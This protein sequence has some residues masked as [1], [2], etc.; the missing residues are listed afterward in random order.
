M[1]RTASAVTTEGIGKDRVGVGDERHR[2]EA[3]LIRPWRRSPDAPRLALPRKA[4]RV[5]EAAVHDG[6]L[7]EYL[8]FRNVRNWF[9]D[10]DRA[11]STRPSR[12][13]EPHVTGLS[14]ATAA[15]AVVAIACNTRSCLRACKTA[16]RQPSGGCLR[17]D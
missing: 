13:C 8:A 4:V 5:T 6:L 11:L 16:K 12:R 1:V 3:R 17:A 10:A 15:D 7:L 14:A 9:L 2:T